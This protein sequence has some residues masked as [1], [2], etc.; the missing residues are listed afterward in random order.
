MAW[1]DDGKTE[2]C[3]APSGQGREHIPYKEGMIQC[4]YVT[5]IRGLGDE[6][7]GS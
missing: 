6:L 3:C 5:G 2:L 4:K 7:H 1:Q